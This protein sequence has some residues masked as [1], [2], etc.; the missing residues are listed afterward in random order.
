MCCVHR[1]RG[2][3]AEGEGASGSGTAPWHWAHN[4]N[5]E[6]LVLEVQLTNNKVVL[7]SKVSW[8]YFPS[9]WVL[10]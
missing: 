9:L 1:P 6:P 5:Q 3:D 4:A 8:H 10:L 7:R 2:G